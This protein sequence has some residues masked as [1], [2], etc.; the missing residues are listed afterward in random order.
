MIHR[1]CDSQI[2][3]WWKVKRTRTGNWNCSVLNLFPS[4]LFHLLISYLLSLFRSI[5]FSSSIWFSSSDG[6]GLVLS[7]LCYSSILL[8]IPPFS[9][10]LFCC[11]NK[12][13]F[14]IRGHETVRFLL[15]QSLT[16]DSFA[17][18][19]SS[20]QDI[21]SCLARQLASFNAHHWSRNSLAHSTWSH[22]GKLV[23]ILMKISQ[24]I[25]VS[26]EAWG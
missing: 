23:R 21:R 9:S 22:D 13:C 5:S 6:L 14:V 17:L 4:L 8:D 2:E 25:K 15:L 10:L 16:S 12:R 1:K 18:T 3:L 11:S 19:D 7:S 24:I 20:L 26:N